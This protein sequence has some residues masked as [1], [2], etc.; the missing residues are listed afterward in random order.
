MWFVPRSTDDVPDGGSVVHDALV[1]PR[2]GVDERRQPWRRMRASLLSPSSATLVFPSFGISKNHQAKT[3]NKKHQNNNLR[4]GPRSRGHGA[5]T[6]G[7]LCHSRASTETTIA[8]FTAVLQS[9]K[10]LYN[11]GVFPDRSAP[12]VNCFGPWACKRGQSANEGRSDRSGR[13][14]DGGGPRRCRLQKQTPD[15]SQAVWLGIG[16]VLPDPDRV[17]PDIDQIWNRPTLTSCGPMSSDVA[18]KSIVTIKGGNGLGGN[19]RRRVAQVPGLAYHYRRPDDLPDRA[20]V[21]ELRLQVLR[22]HAMSSLPPLIDAVAKSSQSVADDRATI[23][24]IAIAMGNE[25]ANPIQDQ[26]QEER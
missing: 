16:Q 6:R 18:P 14:V 9:K 15:L 7:S 26:V 17:W 10:H 23:G 8:G 2:D 19:A 24:D 20:N 4:N 12:S 1:A 25:G 3:K 22:A 13:S 11:A 21:A 5:T